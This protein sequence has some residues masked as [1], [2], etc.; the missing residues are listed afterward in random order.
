M[1]NNENIQGFLSRKGN[2]SLEKIMYWRRM[3]YIEEGLISEPP[4]TS[5]VL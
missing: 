3:G 1:V 5:Y 2:I 4:A